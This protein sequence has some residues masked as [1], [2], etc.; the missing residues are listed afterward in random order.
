MEA[1]Q[2]TQAITKTIAVTP[3][4]APARNIPPIILQLLKHII[5]KMIKG[6]CSFFMAD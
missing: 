3:T 5:S 1:I 2:N 4:M 6:K